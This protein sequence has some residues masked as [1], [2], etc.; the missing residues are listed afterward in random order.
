MIIQNDTLIELLRNLLPATGVSFGDMKNNDLMVAVEAASLRD[1]A[2]V[3]KNDAALQF[4]TLMNHLGADYG[5]RLAVIYN[6]YSPLLR[7]KITLKAFVDRE[8]PEV[9]S[10]EPL[11]P[12]IGWFERETFDMLGIRFAGHLNLK[13]LLLPDDWEG[14]PLRKDYVYPAE[15]Q[16]IE[17]ARA[18]LIDDM[19]RGDGRV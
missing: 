13:R 15:Y 2:A 14:F 8:K 18:D 1:A 7:R 12:G 4:S 19:N 6:L 3:L 10:L 9:E 17:T 5:D 16:S 11:F